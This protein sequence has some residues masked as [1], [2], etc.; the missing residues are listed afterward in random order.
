MRHQRISALGTSFGGASALHA[1]A[2]METLFECMVLRCPPSN[3]LAVEKYELSES[4]LSAWKKQGSRLYPGK[5]DPNLMLKYHF[6]EDLAK[7]EGWKIAA[8]IH[9]P[10]LI[11]H[12]DKD[13]I[14]PID[15][16]YKLDQLM[17]NSKLLVM[18]GAG[19]GFSEGSTYEDSMR[20]IM[21]FF[22]EHLT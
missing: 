18:K 4:E 7:H 13:D 2:V 6:Y 12:G 1:A 19:H 22:K 16:S 15:Q 21:V 11:V 14:V 10:T 17:P 20:E 8:S 3:Y 9:T 5:Y